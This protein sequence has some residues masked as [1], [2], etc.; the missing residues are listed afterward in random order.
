MTR[1]ISF[2]R[3]KGKSTHNNRGLIADNVDVSRTKD[4][5]IIKDQSLAEAYQEIFGAAQGEYN[6]KQK[7]KDRRI[8]D[9][10]DKLFGCPAT[11]NKATEV[12]TNDNKQQSYYEWVIG[13]GSSIDT[14]LVDW[15]DSKGNE[16]KADPEAAQTAALCLKE[17]MLGNQELGIPSYEQR[18][19]NFHV[20]QAIIHM[21]EHTPHLHKEIVPFCDGYKKGM[22]R[23]QSISKALEAM[24]YGV[25]ETAILKWQQSERDVFETICKAHGFEVAAPEKGRGYDIP[26]RQYGK[27]AE[28]ERATKA[29][30]AKLDDLTEQEQRKQDE[31]KQRDREATQQA[32]Q[33]AQVQA[34]LE[35][36]QEQEQALQSRTGGLQSEIAVLT[37]NRDALQAE[38]DDLEPKKTGILRKLV[39]SFRTKPTLQI[40]EQIIEK[41]EDVEK[42]L[43]EETQIELEKARVARKE[44]ENSRNTAIVHED[45][46]AEAKHKAEELLNAAEQ[47]NAEAEALKEAA[48]TAYE[49]RLDEAE[50]EIQR[51]IQDGIKQGIEKYMQQYRDSFEKLDK[52]LESKQQALQRL[53]AA[54]DDKSA[55]LSINPLY[56]LAE[57]H[58]VQA[59]ERIKSMREKSQGG[60]NYERSR[61]NHSKR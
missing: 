5:I 9:Y 34:R 33:A 2:S 28:L 40:A 21:D 52:R 20:V 49:D 46:T 48:A 30:Q 41:A 13:I 61:T 18:N 43:A 32:A 14:A 26:T 23:Q 36:L 45:E 29:E 24:G 4:N 12:I 27:W 59:A 55:D 54:I 37:Q 19:P 6:A 47:K 51:Q 60:Q 53:E 42:A 3:G 39:E 44:A 31:I 50:D 57:S 1:R 56:R 16:Y 38:I 15:T 8:D 7:R 10:F 17:Y 35:V 25:G 11:D 22:T 58:S